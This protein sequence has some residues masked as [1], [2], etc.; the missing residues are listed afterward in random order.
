MEKIMKLELHSHSWYSRGHILGEENIVSPVEMVKEARKKG[1]NGIAITDHNSLESW[2]SL[3][4]MK[5]DDFIIIPGEE[6]ST[7]Q[8]HLIALGIEEAIDPNQ[9]VLETIDKI[10]QQGGITIAPHPY[11]ISKKGIRNFSRFTDA[12]EVFKDE[13]E[14]LECLLEVNNLWKTIG[15]N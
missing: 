14:L 1:L 12:I 3:K 10:H 13:D 8:G 6:I 11:D 15:G 7:R 4:R 2:D 5:F 9:D